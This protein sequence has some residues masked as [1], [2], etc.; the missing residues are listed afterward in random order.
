MLSI[1][2]QSLLVLGF[3]FIGKL[4]KTRLKGRDFEIPLT[5]TTYITTYNNELAS[6]FE[7]DKEIIFFK[8][9]H[10]LLKK[11]RYYLNH[12]DLI[13]KIGVAG[14]KKA[15]EYYTWDKHWLDVLSICRNN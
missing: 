10:E 8:N 2:Q 3:G 13:Q 11:I 7:A 12:Q 6:F 5:G 1:F 14:E 15:R 4:Q 9:K